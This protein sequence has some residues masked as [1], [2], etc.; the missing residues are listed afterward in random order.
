MKVIFLD[1]DGVLNCKFTPGS[2]EKK[3]DQTMIN[4]LVG[5]ARDTGAKIVVSS[6]WRM[7]HMD[8]LTARLHAAGLPVGDIIGQTPEFHTERGLEIRAWLQEHAD[9]NVESFV[10]LDD[11]DDMDGVMSH[12]VKTSWVTGLQDIHVELA[13]RVLSRPAVDLS[14]IFQPR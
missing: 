8:V 7:Y 14:Q 11:D 6:V 5:L 2:C 3:L 13:K 4:R 12:L 10:I 1:V 9:L